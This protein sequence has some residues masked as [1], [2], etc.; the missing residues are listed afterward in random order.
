[1]RPSSVDVGGEYDEARM[2]A[3]V[4]GTVE[5]ASISEAAVRETVTGIVSCVLATSGD[6][7]HTSS[8]PAADLQRLDVGS[9]TSI[10]GSCFRV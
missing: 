9:P 4:Q 6:Q 8:G 10:A 2:R 3:T 7:L 1:M 5:E